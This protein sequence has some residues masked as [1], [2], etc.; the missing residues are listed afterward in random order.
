MTTLNEST[1]TV[2]VD[3]ELDLRTFEEKVK[4][5]ELEK[6]EKDIENKINNLI[7]SHDNNIN[8]HKPDANMLNNLLA[9]IKKL[10]ANKRNEI[11]RQLRNNLSV[12]QDKEKYATIN[13]NNKQ[14]LLAR[15]KA[16]KQ[17]FTN[18]RTS[19]QSLMYRD[20]KFKEKMEKMQEEQN[21]KETLHVHN[22]SCNHEHEKDK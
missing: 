20:K 4:D 5:M 1:N 10:P 22:D 21:K 14:N 18:S 2:T 8:I 12:N 11:I 19:R 3:E 15:L 13:N 7:N 9:G 6:K 16:R 17:E